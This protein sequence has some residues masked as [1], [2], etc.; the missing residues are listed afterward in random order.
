MLIIWLSLVVVCRFFSHLIQSFDFIQWL[1]GYYV[2]ICRQDGWD[3]GTHVNVPLYNTTCH[4]HTHRMV[5][6][7]YASNILN[8]IIHIYF[9]YYISCGIR[10]LKCTTERTFPFC[11][12]CE[13]RKKAASIYKSMCYDD[14]IGIQKVMLVRFCAI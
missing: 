10:L 5:Y 11:Y 1:C 7:R 6:V 2:I 14:G 9:D 12:P 4:T 8:Q 13:C 3:M